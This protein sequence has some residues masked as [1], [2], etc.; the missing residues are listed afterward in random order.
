MALGTISVLLIMVT[1]LATTYTRELKL[2]RSVYDEIIASAGAEWMFEYAMLKIR[3]HREGFAD[4][5]TENDGDASILSTLSDRSK[6][7]KSTYTILANSSDSTFPLQ[8]SEHLIV[9]LFTARES[10]LTPGGNSKLPFANLDVEKVTS[11]VT[12][13]IE[14]LSWTL[15]A[16]SGSESIG[17]TGS[18]NISPEKLGI[19]RT[20]YSQCYDAQ[21]ENISCSDEN[22]V[23]EELQYFADTEKSVWDFL[24]EV[25]DPYLMVYNDSD[26]PKSIRITSNENTPFSL[27]TVTVT[28]ES[29]KND[30][31]QTF[32]FVEDKSKYYDAL[33]YGVYN[34]GE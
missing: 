6:N 4:K 17:M 33:K 24:A 29:R 28:A 18:G 10:F 13:W 25:G 8:T 22:L 3:N 26:S 11:L 32:R 2:S 34:N 15:V 20:R 31:L 16:Q 27:P 7:L 9:P 1:G 30:S 19:V 21:W 23:A 12:E 14:N 5:I